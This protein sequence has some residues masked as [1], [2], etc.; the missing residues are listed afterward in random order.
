MKRGEIYYI[1]RRDAIGSETMKA[2]P[3]VTVSNDTL[4]STSEV[5]MVVYLTTQPKKELPTHVAIESTGVSSTALCEHIDHVS[6]VLIGDYCG[7]CTEEEMADIEAAMLAALGIERNKNIT[8]AECFK[9][10]TEMTKEDR[11][12]MEEL[13]RVQAERDRYARMLDKLLGGMEQ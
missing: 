6:K 7:T 5:V 8:V 9:L 4:N 1:A 10:A 2:R 11:M 12:L 13:Q 3:G